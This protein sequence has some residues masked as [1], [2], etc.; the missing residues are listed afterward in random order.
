VSKI[1]SIDDM[2]EA[3]CADLPES[4][5]ADFVS[6]FENLAS[7]L[8]EQLSRC[9]QINS[10]GAMWQGKALG[11]LCA[12]FEP[13]TEGQECPPMIDEGDPDGEWD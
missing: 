8:A 12:A 13:K 11:G 1:L 7:A 10:D 4:V 6:G 5:S 3:A 2:L 9:Y